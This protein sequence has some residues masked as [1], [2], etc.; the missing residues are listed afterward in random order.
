MPCV[1]NVSKDQGLT[2]TLIR[3]NM[4][5]QWDFPNLLQAYSES[6]GTPLFKNFL[7]K[8]FLKSEAQHTFYT[9]YLL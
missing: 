3:K 2:S 5:R 7:Q 4:A 6:N 8:N 1:I 9:M